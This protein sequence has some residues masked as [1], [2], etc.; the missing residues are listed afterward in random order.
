MHKWDWYQTTV[1]MSI[2]SVISRFKGSAIHDLSDIKIATP[3]NGYTHAVSFVRGDHA[4]CTL[5]YGG[6]PGVNILS[7]GP[8]APALAEFMRSFDEHYPTRVDACVDLARPGLFD[9]LARG[10]LRFAVRKGLT[11]NQQGDWERGRARTLY[12]G[13]RSSPVRLRMYEK[14]CQMIDRYGDTS[15]DPFWVRVEVEVK[16]KIHAR[17]IV[18]RWSPSDA[19][20]RAC[21]WL[22]ELWEALGWGSYAP[23]AIGTVREE[24]DTLRQRFAFARQYGRV[25]EQW[26]VDAGSPEEFV[27]QFRALRSEMGSSRA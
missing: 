3:R 22:S 8:D 9:E 17:P 20:T 6:N 4:H 12:I 13:S 25:C 1:F 5:F 7:S 27:K 2:E 26:I 11:I 24:I 16:P 23:F 18:S 15:A 10:M 14:G 21:R 19:F